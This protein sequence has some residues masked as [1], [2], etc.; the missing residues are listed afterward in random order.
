MRR[1]RLIC[2]SGTICGAPVSLSFGMQRGMRHTR[3]NPVSGKLWADFITALI[4][5]LLAGCH[6]PG[7]RLLRLEV[8]QNDQLVL[9]TTFD[10]PDHEGPADFWRRTGTEP[11][12]A[13]E[14]VARVKADGDNPL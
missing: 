4:A 7:M 2:I 5:I 8:Y 11:F 12:A 10:A 9:R 1:V 3:L 14:Q 13:D 6:P